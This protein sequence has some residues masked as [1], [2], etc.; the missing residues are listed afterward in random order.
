MGDAPHETAMSLRDARDQAVAVLSQ[1][2]ADSVIDEDELERRIER[3]EGAE[4][5][6]QVE[7]VTR[8]LVPAGGLAGLQL[9]TMPALARVEDIQPERRLVAVFGE[10]KQH[11]G[12]QPA[13]VNRVL[14]VFG[15]THLDFRNAQLG[16]GVT[17]IRV[18]CVLGEVQIIV[19]PGMPVDVDCA[20]F[21]A[22]VERDDPD[23]EVAPTPG[24]PALRITG[25]ATFG[26]IEIRERMS[27]ETAREA[28][29]RRKAERKQKRSR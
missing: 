14:T 21:M 28:K 11:S 29:K 16:A 13:R 19:P 5:V 25:M 23:A 17:E 2:Y 7:T 10:V 15:S 3:V 12:W 1:R 9:A 4:S 26:S 18:R 8:D 6:L 20:L 24:R 22:S 27:G